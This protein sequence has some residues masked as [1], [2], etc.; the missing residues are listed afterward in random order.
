MIMP[1]FHGH[2]GRAGLGIVNGLLITVLAIFFLIEGKRKNMLSYLGDCKL[3]FLYI[4]PFLVLLIIIPV[5]MSAGVLME[6]TDLIMRDFYELHKPAL[7]FLVFLFS[8][9]LAIKSSRLIFFERSLVYLFFLVVLLG[10][11]HYINLYPI[12]T[13]Y[14]GLNNIESGR[15][16]TPFSNPYDYAFFMTF[17]V[18]YFFSKLLFSSFSRYI[19]VFLLSLIMLILPQSRSVVAGF[20]VGFFVITPMVLTYFG[21]NI[22]QNKIRVSLLLYYFCFIVLVLVLLF[23]LPYLLENFS[24]LT[25]Q[26]VR[27]FENGD[28]G[29]SA[30]HRLNQF[31]FAIDR[32]NSSLII[33]LF[34]NGPSKGEM[35]LVESIYSYL[36]FRYGLMGFLCYFFILFLSAYQCFRILKSMNAKNTDYAFFMAV[37]LWLLTV[38]LLSIGN[39]FT[40][41]VRLSFFYYTLLGLVGGYYQ[42]YFRVSKNEN[43]LRNNAVPSSK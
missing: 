9:F 36:L 30:G 7:N 1:T 38:P 40:E 29:N 8:F 33:F 21:L 11:N 17:F 43:Y 34:G 20:I 13:M 18:Y 4:V 26:F 32:A 16:S 5:S 39:N 3:A 10:L 23:S 27:F 41:Q 35:A 6:G 37:L 25:G 28:I 15:V 2:M 14:T 12:S 19:I 22:K 31:L 42:F 24:Y